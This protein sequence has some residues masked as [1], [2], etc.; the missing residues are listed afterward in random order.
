MKYVPNIYSA[1]EIR[2][3]NTMGKGTHLKDKTWIPARP[4]G[5][6]GLCLFTRLKRAW[7]VFTGKCD[8]LKWDES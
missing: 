7:M 8:V 6:W 3:W 1:T 5:F 4:M 2:F